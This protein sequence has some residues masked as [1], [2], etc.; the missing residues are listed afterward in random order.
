[1][2]A[3]ERLISE[4]LHEFQECGV[5]LEYDLITVQYT[6]CFILDLYGSHSQLIGLPQSFY[7][8]LNLSPQSVQVLSTDSVLRGVDLKTLQRIVVFLP[9]V[10][11]LLYRGVVHQVGGPLR[12][13]RM[14]RGDQPQER[15]V[16]ELFEFF[17]TLFL[18]VVEVALK[19]ELSVENA[20]GLVV[21]VG[22]DLNSMDVLVDLLDGSSNAML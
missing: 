14:N 5:G 11:F 18:E 13:I 16:H 22:G 6:P 1:V 8:C 15:I 17:W 12:F 7:L 19:D 21:A 10:I 2:V 3:P 9:Y 20:R 4:V